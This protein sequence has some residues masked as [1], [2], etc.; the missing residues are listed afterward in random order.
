MSDINTPGFRTSSF[1]GFNKKDVIDFITKL[2]GEYRV[3]ISRLK[4]SL[5][6]RDSLISSLEARSAEDKKYIDSLLQKNADFVDYKEQ[7]ESELYILKQKLI[8]S[9]EQAKT[10]G[11]KVS[12]AEIALDECLKREKSITDELEMLIH[13]KKLVVD[14]ELQARKR[15]EDIEKESHDKL[16]LLCEKYKAKFTEISELYIHYKDEAELMIQS[17]Q[18]Q[19]KSMIDIFSDLSAGL[20]NIE[21]SFIRITDDICSGEDKED[22][23]DKPVF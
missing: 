2:S 10:A 7:K 13:D 6:E 23:E 12:N 11:E 4:A 16:I 14:L 15:A 22:K 9:E 18:N 3:E 17:S 21:G 1:G 20:E 5:S 19:L 8:H